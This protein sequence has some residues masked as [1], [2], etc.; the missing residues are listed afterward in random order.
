VFVNPDAYRAF[1]KTG[2]WPE[3]TILVM[4]SR[5]SETH[6]SINQGGHFQTDLVGIE[7]NVKD[8]SS[9][10]GTWN[11]YGFSVNGD[12]HQ[13]SARP[14][15]HTASCFNCHGAKTAVENTFAQFYPTIYDVAER[16][17]TINPGF[18]K[19]P[20]PP[21]KLYQ[22]LLNGGWKQAG[23]ALDDAAAHS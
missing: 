1:L 23:P 16:K 11:F 12:Q 18:E 5:F 8:S 21:G 6:A 19:M 15:P 2:H 3:K 13:A 9:P 4:E 20:V 10:A 17:G 14:V 7:A 22:T